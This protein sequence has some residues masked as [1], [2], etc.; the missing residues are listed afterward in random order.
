MSTAYPSR[1]GSSA[2]L[3]PCLPTFKKIPGA[4]LAPSSQQ[5]TLLPPFAFL[6]RRI[7]C[8][9]H[10]LVGA[11][12]PWLPRTAETATRSLRTTSIRRRP[13]T[14]RTT[15]RPRP[16]AAAPARLG[17]DATTTTTRTAHPTAARPGGR[18]S[19]RTAGTAPTKTRKTTTTGRARGGTTTKTTTKRTTTTMMTFRRYVPVVLG[20]RSE[21]RCSPGCGIVSG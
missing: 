21:L 10:H 7:L 15:R 6:W 3:V 16:V 5:L 17:A 11:D 1:T 18:K 14:S 8:G 12:S 9:H 2:D 20:G 19:A 4:R 13:P